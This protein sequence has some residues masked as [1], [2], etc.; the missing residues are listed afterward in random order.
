MASA[1]SEIAQYDG[2]ALVLALSRLR[3]ITGLAVCCMTLA[4]GAQETP[5]S[6]AK[7]DESGFVIRS[8][9]NLIVVPVVVRDAKGKPV[10]GLTRDDFEVFDNKKPQAISHFST[11]TIEDVN[12][13]N[14][15]EGKAKSAAPEAAPLR[16]IG[17]FFD[18]YHLEFGDLAQI[19]QA[20]KH[21]LEKNLDSGARV[22]IFSASGRNDIE[23]TRDRDKLDLALAKLHV[24][25]NLE[26]CPKIS[27]YLAQRVEDGDQGA[28]E[29]AKAM[30]LPCRCKS[31]PCPPMEFPTREES[32][33]VLQQN[34]MRVR[35][36]LTALDN[37]VR[38]MAGMPGERSMAIL[39]DGF[40]DTYHEN[41]IDVLIDH[42]LRQHVVINALDAR[43]LYATLP[44]ESYAR[45]GMQRQ[46]D[47]LAE[48]AEGTG[49]VFVE[50]TNDLEGGLAR[51][52]SPHTTYILGFSPENFKPDGQF[53]KL[54]VKLVNSAHLT[55]QAR[56]GYFAPKGAANSAVAEKEAMENAIFSS[57]DVPGLPI[58]ISTKFV[59]VDSRN[60]K[61]DVTVAAD[62]HSVRF[63]KADGRNL[64]DLTLIVVLFDGDGNYVTG[65][66]Q[67]VNLNLTD[68]ELEKLKSTGGEGAAELNAKPGNYVVR[69][70]VRES[71]SKQLGAAS[72]RVE[73]P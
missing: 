53:H 14:A 42:A 73:I 23:F 49:G 9:S 32:H 35:T 65:Q 72:Q 51:V 15:A 56:R 71:E 31:E 58:Q 66:N 1:G 39:S 41:R 60:T 3:L 59:R 30:V 22:A 37:A 70:V 11:E 61:I 34:E 24:V 26:S 5:H 28:L 4:A 27:V 54:Q 33:L 40:L 21:Y 64:D 6:G 10:S 20:A 48:A 67:I 50:N 2:S 25:L 7:S 57:Q 8:Q 47:I 16:F 63:R 13:P 46:A 12:P 55:V 19:Q 45:Q 36:T 44:D 18:D 38:R 17:L 68:A 62:L 69:A 43:G 29:V 52:E